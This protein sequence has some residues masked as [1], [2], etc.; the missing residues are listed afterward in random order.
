MLLTK[1]SEYALL[2]MII[3]AKHDEPKPVDVLAESLNISKS[4]LAKL[5][6]ALSRNGILM[7][8]KGAKGGFALLKSPE[9]ISI[10]D[11]IK[12]VETNAANIFEC[13]DSLKSCPG[14]EGKASICT[15]WPYLNKLQFKVDSFLSQITLKE[16]IE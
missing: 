16:L 8:Y 15:I 3:I 1:A 6:Q 14:G 13:S 2:S 11:I 10:L 12:T 9:N 5:L 4:F 7:S